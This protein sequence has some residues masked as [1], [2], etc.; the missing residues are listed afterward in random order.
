[1]EG[2]QPGEGILF[3]GENF[4]RHCGLIYSHI[5]IP[6]DPAH[7]IAFSMAGIH[8]FPDYQDS[9]YPDIKVEGTG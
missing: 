6:D 2:F 5:E 8:F 7:G 4:N 1:M 3:I 9:A